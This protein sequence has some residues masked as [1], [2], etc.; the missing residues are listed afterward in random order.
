[1]TDLSTN[2]LGLPLKNPLMA[3]ASPWTAEV[4]SARELE[5]AGVAAL[6]MRSIFEEQIRSDVAD[7]YAALEYDLHPEALE[8][9]RADLPMQ[10]GSEDYLERLAAIKSAVDIPVIASINCINPDRWLQFARQ[11][12]AAGADALELNLYDIPDSSAVS[13]TS[14]EAR[15][16][17]LV[18][19]VVREVT[20]PVAVKIAP[21]YS[22]LMNMAGKFVAA[23]ARGLV[24]FNRFLQPDIDIEEMTLA[25]KTNYS[26]PGDM[27]LPLRWVALL[28]DQVECS[29]ALGGGVHDAES[30]IKALLAGAD[31]VQICSVL[32]LRPPGEAVPELLEGL[33][34]WMTEK[35]FETL[36]AFRGR[37][38]ERNLSDRAGFE[39]VHYVRTL[40]RKQA[41]RA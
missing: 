25:E 39:R 30:L 2:Y 20:L 28:R 26:R 19:T 35:R 10:M 41:D 7:M 5:A 36:D 33:E 11:V 8:Y 27:L 23:G 21:F 24:L 14:I 3:A 15:H 32:F 38:S 31:G 9:L 18:E 29:L 22:A 34:K 4:D 37:L 16:I 1:M 6:V 13:G 12:E 17:E 40:L